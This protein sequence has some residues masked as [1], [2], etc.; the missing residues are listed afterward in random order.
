MTTRPGSL[1]DLI[2]ARQQSSFVGRLGELAQF[3]ENLGL[4]V[5]DDRRRFIFNIHGDAGVGKTYLT[6]QL[7]QLA[8]GK[9]A[10]TAYVDETADD[11]IAAMNAIAGQL[12]QAGARLGGFQKRASTYWRRRQEMESDP[13]APDDISSFLTKTAI[14]I[15]LAAARGIP[16]AGSLLAPV[17]PAGTAEQANRARAYL[18]RRLRDH[19]DVRLLLSPT[20][21]LTPVFVK[22]LERAAAARPITLFIDTYE[23]SGLVLD[24][25]LRR[26]YGGQYGGLPMTLVTTIS[27][28]KPLSPSLWGDY[29]PVIADVPLEPF[30]DTEARQ[31][32]TSKGIHNEEM[33]KVIL[34]LSGRLPLWLATL[35]EARPGSVADIGDPAGGAVERFLRWEENPARRQIAIAAALPRALDQEV[36]AEVAGAGD[37]RELFSWLCGLPFVTRRAGGWAYHEVVRAAM[38]RLQYAQAP[39][40]W[41]SRQATLAQAYA[42]WI[43]E[44]AADDSPGSASPRSVNCAR[45]QAYHLLCADPDANLPGTLM[46]A[47][48]AAEHGVTHARQWAELIADAGK[49]TGHLRIFQWGQ[50][51]NDGIRDGDLTGYLTE[52]INHANLD[53]GT[54]GAALDLRGE[55]HRLAERYDEAL[56]DFNRAID[57]DPH[58]AWA[59][60]SRGQA[61]QATERYDD[62]LADLNRAIELRPEYTWAIVSR[63]ETYLD[64]ENDDDALADFNRAVDLDPQNTWAIV[65]RAQAYQSMKRNDEALADFNRAVDL[66]PRDAWAIASR[67]RAYREMGRYDEALAD[68]NRAVDLDPDYPWSITNRAQTYQKMRRYDDALADYARLVELNP[69]SAGAI[70]GRGM[71]Y[72]EMG[73]Y[74]DALAD[75][76]RVIE[77]HP[78]YAFPPVHR[79]KTYQLMGRYDEALADY[80]R[81]IDIEPKYPWAHVHRGQA[82]QEMGRYDEALA[83]F[84]R[85]IEIEPEYV[86][87]F[88]SRAATYQLMK[89]YDDALADFDR[90][91]ELDPTDDDHSAARAEALRL[92]RQVATD[93]LSQGALPVT[94]NGQEKCIIVNLCTSTGACNLSGEREY[95]AGRMFVVVRP[96]LPGFVLV[97]A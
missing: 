70:L 6:T 27:G 22:E 95:S 8:A 83:D 84:G 40:E 68:L 3:Q 7:R 25:W 14:T 11:A 29:F 77:L 47:V 65:S 74:H 1:Q 44:T 73:R 58:N 41:T 36:L 38:L 5:G 33:T 91:I 90:A 39:S 61:Y 34:S 76:S 57:L 54:L 32:L 56:A 9:G 4:P 12:A 19:A 87:A 28:Q 24:D 75:F 30:S 89:R 97:R 17:D 81:A 93:D 48:Q 78:E 10:L 46:Q 80:A 15:G 45:E 60:A 53:S 69:E 86:Q 67:G 31:F 94:G 49:D 71:T 59:I 50:R 51:L 85:A 63:A 43:H 13:T 79:G 64:M 82:Y 16:V 92:T 62:A 2:R 66:D 55:E 42:R 23:R 72:R 37:A 20:D 96:R 52:L 18:S 21:E 35:A 26:L 88:A